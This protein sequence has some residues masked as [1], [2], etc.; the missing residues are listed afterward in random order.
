M[1][2]RTTGMRTDHSR[3]DQGIATF[4]EQAVPSMRSVPGYAGA[5]LLV[6]RETGEGLAV[7]YWETVAHLNAAEQAGQQARRQ[8]SVATGAEITDIDRF[9]MML[10]DRAA[11]PSAPTFSRVNQFYAD[12]DRLEAGIAFVRDN[13]L[14]NL[15]K[16][17]GYQSMLV[18]VNRTT[19]RLVATSNWRTAEDRA[20]SE[21]AV[22]G[23]RT[24]ATRILGADRVEVRAFEVAVVEIKQ[25]T[26]T[27]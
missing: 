13:V 5:A 20:V 18:G 14:P 25:P 10:V 9:E 12:L 26:R 21:A 4:K 3:V 27:R 24:E 15:S 11:D 19:G 23:L 17:R 6:D 8:T 1:F 2:A 7:T 16:Q 22:A